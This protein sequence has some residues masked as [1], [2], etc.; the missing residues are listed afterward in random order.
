LGQAKKNQPVSG[1]VTAT[2]GAPATRQQNPSLHTQI[3]KS[4][5]ITMNLAV[6]VSFALIIFTTYT[7]FPPKFQATSRC[8]VPASAS[9]TRHHC[10]LQIIMRLGAGVPRETLMIAR[11]PFY[12]R[13]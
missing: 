9:Q 11:F 7:P 6:T 1:A 2:I 13:I 3:I 4:Y 10:P 5:L 8:R 12:Y